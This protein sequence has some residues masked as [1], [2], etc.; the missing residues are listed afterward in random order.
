MHII[1]KEV[2]LVEPKFNLCA[3]LVDMMCKK[4][5]EKYLV[6]IEASK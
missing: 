4:I 6:S 5:L 3:S 1:E 2:D